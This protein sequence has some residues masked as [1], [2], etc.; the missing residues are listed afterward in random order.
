[1][2]MPSGLIAHCLLPQF[3]CTIYNN[4]DITIVSKRV[5]EVEEDS[6]KNGC[7]VMV[8]AY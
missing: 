1:M 3:V 6:Y 7:I 5:Q 8:F 4:T 2:S